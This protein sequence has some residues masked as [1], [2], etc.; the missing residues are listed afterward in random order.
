MRIGILGTG[1]VGQTIATRLVQLGHEVRMGSREPGNEKAKGWVLQ[2]GPRASNGTFADAAAFGEIVFNCT[3]G[4]GSMA[5]LKAAGARNLDGKVLIDVANP[6]NTS[7]VPLPELSFCNDDSLAERIQREFPGVKVVK[8]L[9]T[10]NC[11]VMV[12]PKKIPG[13]HDVFVSGND[14]E[15]KATVKEILSE[16]GWDNPIDLGDITSAR[17]AEMLLPIWL[18]LM[19]AFKSPNFNFHIAK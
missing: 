14:P 13:E 1:M 7:K 3:S 16:F 8:S 11:Q 18:R 17:G 9:N 19:V 2:A 12:D 4:D 15:A 10:M 5:A 6:L